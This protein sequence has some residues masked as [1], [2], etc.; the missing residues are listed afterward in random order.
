MEKLV[1][2]LLH[3][4]GYSGSNIDKAPG[5]ANNVWL[6]PEVVIRLNEGRFRNAFQHEAEVLSRLSAIL[7]VPNVLAKGQHDQSG[8][9]II[10]ERLPGSN[11]QDAWPMLSEKQRRSFSESIGSMILTLHS[12]P[13]EDWMQNPWANDAFSTRNARDAYHAPVHEIDWIADSAAVTRPDLL[14]LVDEVRQF[15]NRRS[16]VFE[17][18]ETCL[19]HADLHFRNVMVDG[20]QITGLIDFEGARPAPRSTELDMLF[21]WLIEENQKA[22]GEYNGLISGMM[23]TYPELFDDQELVSKLE[24]YE[25][26]WQLVQLHHWHPGARWMSDPARHIEA[27]LRG[28]FGQNVARLLAAV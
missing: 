7:P 27:V 8:E 28:S 2:E 14:H 5:F 20:D 10:L 24:I 16:H 1:S 13:V 9:F 4:S 6:T 25:L 22:P 26:L 18:E 23:S 15:V 3:Q 17:L 21:R 12:M 11:L 19:I